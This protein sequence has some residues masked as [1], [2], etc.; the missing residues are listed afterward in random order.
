MY[1]HTESNV[2]ELQ[3]LWKPTA[4][5]FPEMGLL[6]IRIYEVESRQEPWTVIDFAFV[7]SSSSRARVVMG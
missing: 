3:L 7:S 5:N 2:T 4:V 6:G 1:S